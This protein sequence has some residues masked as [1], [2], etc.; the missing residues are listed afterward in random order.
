M[1]IV[2]KKN[3]AVFAIARDGS[4]R[5]RL[6]NSDLPV[7]SV[8]WSPD[9]KQFSFAAVIH[10]KPQVRLTSADG[11]ATHVIAPEKYEQCRPLTWLP[12][13]DLLFLACANHPGHGIG[14]HGQLGLAGQVLFVVDASDPKHEL[15][16]LADDV[17]GRASI[18]FLQ[19]SS[20]VP[21]L[22]SLPTH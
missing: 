3:Q 16:W 2:K 10:G 11:S 9:A 20:S 6:T 13:T 15:Y 21:S 7:A 18:V 1:W 5:Q 4:A 14:P 17:L 8:L 12:E 19:P 22:D